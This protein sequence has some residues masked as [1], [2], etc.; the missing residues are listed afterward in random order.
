MFTDYQVGVGFGF[1]LRAKRPAATIRSRENPTCLQLF[2]IAERIFIITKSVIFLA[3]HVI[4]KNGV[5]IPKEQSVRYFV[6][7][8]SFFLCAQKGLPR[9]TPPAARG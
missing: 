6:C 5:V 7:G 8:S 2:F 3:I 1:V 9:E 4:I